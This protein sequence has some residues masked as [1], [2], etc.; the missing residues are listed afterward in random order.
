MNVAF[1]LDSAALSAQTV[2]NN[3]P[4]QNWL[5]LIV[6]SAWSLMSDLH[7]PFTVTVCALKLL[8][9]TAEYDQ[10]IATLE[11]YVICNVIGCTLAQH[12]VLF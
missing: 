4:P 11:R 7:Q 12:F 9:S 5:F 3:V 2:A 6:E 8:T 1:Q 10:G